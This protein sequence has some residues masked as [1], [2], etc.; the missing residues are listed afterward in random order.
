MRNIK[1]KLR[2]KNLVL[3]ENDNW[4]TEFCR[5]HAHNGNN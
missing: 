3:L 4:K 1:E 2:I 5:K